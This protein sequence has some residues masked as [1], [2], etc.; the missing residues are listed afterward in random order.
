MSVLPLNSQARTPSPGE[1]A[2]PAAH[3]GPETAS[4]A[5]HSEQVLITEHEVMLGSAAAGGAL[6]TDPRSR[7]IIAL[8][9]IFSRPNWH[10]DASV[11]R[12]VRGGYLENARMAREMRHL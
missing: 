9:R 12:S 1:S 11:R 6:P 10:V 7:W 4:V 8:R 3:P 5:E 2:E